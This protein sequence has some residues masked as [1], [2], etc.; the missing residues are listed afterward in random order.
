MTSKEGREKEMIVLFDKKEQCC[1]CA[2]CMNICPTQA[3]T[4]KAD[5][6]GFTFPEINKDLCTEC[7]LCN[8]VCAFQNIPVTGD[9]P[10]A[11]YAAINKN[12]NV[13]SASASGGIFGALASLVFDKEGVVFGCAYNENMEPEH[14]CVDNQLD[15]KKIQG[16]KY[17]QSNIN[18]TYSDA[19][20]YLKDGRWVL[21][22]G[23]PCQ[24]AG[25]KSY[26]GKDYNNLITADIICHGV[27]SVEVFKGYINYLEDKLKGKVI[28]LKFRDKSKG[29][30]H[31]EKVIYKKDGILKEK[32]IQPF[33]SYYHSYFLNGDIL[34]EN[35]YECK[36]ACSSRVGDFTMGDYWG[37]EKVHPEIVTK[38]GVSVL[39]V[40]SK[41]GIELIDDLSK[42]L[43]L[44]ESLFEQAR[45]QNGPLNRPNAK[46]EKRDIILKTWR[47]GDYKA[48]ADEYYRMNKKLII[49]SRCKMLI[50]RSIKKH[51]KRVLRRG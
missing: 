42:C 1:C 11:T 26:L 39:L 9:G 51:L 15:I 18:T 38:E 32:L 29:W 10:M 2:A 17:V 3:I 14:I 37:I 16:S 22:T 21:F 43:Q 12:S 19:K 4:I 31:I 45:V 23:T 50:P 13:L 28:D 46:S 30:G 35:C 48:V 7:G 33:N 24:I 20:G 47:E 6:D 34:R 49:L 27:P 41:K 5:V 8:K 36:Y 25:L 40:N 44:T